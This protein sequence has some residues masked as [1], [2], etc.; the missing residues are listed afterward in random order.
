[1]TSH[2]PFRRIAFAAAIALLLA[3]TGCLQME[4]S[5]VFARDGS[6]IVTWNV[7]VPSAIRPA[8]EQAARTGQ[9][10]FNLT[11]LPFWPPDRET[12][13]AY[14]DSHPGIELREYRDYQENGRSKLEIVVLAREALPAF[15]SEAF[16]GFMLRRDD[17]GD[18]TL[19]RHIPIL[20]DKFHPAEL[21]AL[22]PLLQDAVLTLKVQVPT[23]IIE[24]NGRQPQ[25][26]QSVW[27][28]TAEPKGDELP[29]F[30][31]TL[32]KVSLKW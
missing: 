32:D 17:L 24:G 29:F 16:P 8:L 30:G 1:M 22:R 12:V 9:E 6:C 7:S 28:W 20:K 27:I 13:Q 11:R 15:N 25:F 23:A 4:Q 18:L 3:A 10:K 31:N 21:K 14:C 19:T 5:F 26:N 2:A